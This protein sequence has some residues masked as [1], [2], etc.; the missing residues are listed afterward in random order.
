MRTI[1]TL[2]LLLTLCSATPLLCATPP[3]DPEAA[4]RREVA[5]FGEESRP[6]AGAVGDPDSFGRNSRYLGLLYSGIVMVVPDCTSPDVP[7]GPDDRCVTLPTNGTTRTDFDLPDIG[8]VTLPAR[9][10][11]TLLCHWLTPLGAYTLQ[12]TGTARV[13]ARMHFEPYV[14]IESAALADPT[15]INPDTGAPFGGRLESGFSATHLDQRHLD[16]GER[17]FVR[18][19]PGRT[20]L[21]GFLSRRT[22][23]QYYGLSEAQAAAVFRG[24]LRLRF[25]LRGSVRSAAS[26]ILRYGVRI[27]GD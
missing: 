8:R 21:S 19:P 20:C 16:P 25:G 10:S 5:A 22:L 4:I 11:N 18:N 1:R 13:D 17:V 12:N 9:S 3:L 7:H 23:V 2:A 6:D 15:L 27:M 26:A 24:E 14:V